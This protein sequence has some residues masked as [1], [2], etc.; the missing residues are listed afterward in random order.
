MVDRNGSWHGELCAL[1]G[2]FPRFVSGRAEAFGRPEKK[3]N[4]NGKQESGDSRGLLHVTITLR[5]ARCVIYVI[6]NSL[7]CFGWCR[8]SG[9]R[10]RRTE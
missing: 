5:G 4:L 6:S 7:R 10:A 3:W 8:V 2:M 9:S 1:E